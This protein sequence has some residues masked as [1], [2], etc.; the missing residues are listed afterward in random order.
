MSEIINFPNTWGATLF[1]FLLHPNSKIYN[2][3]FLYVHT[4][5]SAIG[6]CYISYVGIVGLWSIV[7]KKIVLCGGH[8]DWQCSWQL[9]YCQSRQYCVVLVLLINNYKINVLFGIGIRVYVYVTQNEF[10]EC[11]RKKFGSRWNFKCSG[12]WGFERGWG[13]ARRRDRW[14]WCLFIGRFV[15]IHGI[16]YPN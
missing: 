14:H 11:P 6:I 16:V 12:R 7:P 15:K 3:G 4:K 13:S 8:R 2:P 1:I 9:C 10:V 5:V